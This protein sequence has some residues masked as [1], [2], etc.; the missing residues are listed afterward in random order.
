MKQTA[1]KTAKLLFISTMALI[2]S[3]CALAPGMNAGF[4]GGISNV[5]LPVTQGE[6]RIPENVS[7]RP[8]T[9]ELVMEQQRDFYPQKGGVDPEIEQYLYRLGPGDILSIVVW[10]HPE[11]TIPAGAERDAVQSGT[12]INENGTLYFPYA[13]IVPVAGKNVREVRSILTKKLSRVIEN[14]QLEVRMAAFRSKRVY[15][16]GEVKSP[17][18]QQVTDIA[19]TILEMVNQAGGF[20]TEADRR[21]ITL[22]RND[23]SYRVDLLALYENGNVEQNILLKAGDVINVPDRQNNK[24]FMLGEFNNPGSLLMVKS[25]KTL[26]EAISDSGDINNNTADPSQIFVMRG[27]GD[28]PEIFHLNASTPDAMLLADR[29]PLKPRDVVYVDV[30][31]LVRWNRVITN[32]L[33]TLTSLSTASG[34]SFPLFKGGGN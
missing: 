27:S 9:A 13:G 14:V 18:I 2:V 24:V 34:T 21:N 26:A 7:I 30:S 16:V 22:T 23:R 11:L 31:E 10:D 28:K 17:G 5:K 4:S 33:P 32:V 15:V 3:G 1:G 8:I 12:V 29:F 19:P 6:T 20:T 25:R